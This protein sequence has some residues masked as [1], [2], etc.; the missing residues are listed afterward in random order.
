MP[1]DGKDFALPA[2]ETDEMLLALIEGRKRIETNWYSAHVD[3]RIGTNP[4]CATNTLYLMDGFSDTARFE[5]MHAL[6][7]ALPA[8]GANYC[9]VWLFNDKEATHAD[10]LALYDRA[11]AARRGELS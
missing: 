11:I 9:A 4:Q 5:A 8:P 10:I 6:G 1:F 2:V 3:R 7:R